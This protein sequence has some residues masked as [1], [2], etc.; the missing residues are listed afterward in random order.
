MQEIEKIINYKFKKKKLLEDA[1]THSSISSGTAFERLEFLG[2]LILDAIVG[3][4]I[5]KKFPDKNEAFLTDLKSAY[6]NKNYLKEVADKLKLKNYVKYIGNEIKKTDKF[7]EAL[8]GAIYLDG[9]WKKTEKFIKEFILKKELEPL[10]DY[11]S[12]I[13]NYARKFLK[14]IPEYVLVSIEGPPH[15]RKFKVKVK[16]KGIRKTGIGTG[17]S[18]KDAELLA[19]KSLYEKLNMKENF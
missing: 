16:I 6:V 14:A 4:Y 18:L 13:F 15:K 11:K 12:L 7:L 10:K 8:I 3:I 19:A 9:G 17:D 1:L 5:F 2:D